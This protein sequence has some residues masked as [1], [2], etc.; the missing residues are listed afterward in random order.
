[1]CAFPTYFPCLLEGNTT[2]MYPVLFTQYVFSLCFSLLLLPALH[3]F[4]NMNILCVVSCYVKSFLI[5]MYFLRFITF[6]SFFSP[7]L[8]V[9]LSVSFPSSLSVSLWFAPQVSGYLSSFLPVFSPRLSFC[10]SLLSYFFFLL[11]ATSPLFHFIPDPFSLSPLHF[12]TFYL[13]ISSFFHTYSSLSFSP[14]SL[15]LHFSAHSIC[16]SFSSL[17][18]LCI[19]LSPPSHLPLSHSLLS[20]FCHSRPL[21]LLGVLNYCDIPNI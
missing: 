16:L 1:M 13:P 4:T 6:I 21:F 17:S 9:S 3:S 14:L 8:L 5:R 19:I 12:V 15:F 11:L 18:S 20:L 2:R 7:Y 10:T